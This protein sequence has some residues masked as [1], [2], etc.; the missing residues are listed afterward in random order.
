MF[1]SCKTGVFLIKSSHLSMCQHCVN[2]FMV[3]LNCSFI[4]FGCIKKKR[5]GN[6]NACLCCNKRAEMNF[7][8]CIKQSDERSR[9]GGWRFAHTIGLIQHTKAAHCVEEMWAI[10]E[11]NSNWKVWM[12]SLIES[13]HAERQIIFCSRL[14]MLVLVGLSHCF[15]VRESCQRRNYCSGSFF[16]MAERKGLFFVYLPCCQ[17]ANELS[18]DMGLVVT[19]QA[20]L[21]LGFHGNGGMK[22]ARQPGCTVWVAVLISILCLLTIQGGMSCSQHRTNQYSLAHTHGL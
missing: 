11:M 19:L 9:Y 21:M 7:S 8:V 14:F 13:K 18:S 15:H 6:G 16:V 17:G 10:A 2:M 3:Q 1:V 4:P 5:A 20:Q 12:A 22:C